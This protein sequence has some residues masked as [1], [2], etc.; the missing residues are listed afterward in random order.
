MRKFICLKGVPLSIYISYTHKM[1]IMPFLLSN[2]LHKDVVIYEIYPKLCKLKSPLLNTHLQK[3]ILCDVSM[4]NEIEDIYIN[5][6]VDVHE[7]YYRDWMETDLLWILNT[8]FPFYSDRCKRQSIRQSDPMHH[9]NRYLWFLM[10]NEQKELMYNQANVS[11]D[12][13]EIMS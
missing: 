6:S 13:F 3:S 1:E 9:N 2:V 5:L 10:T 11:K 12:W 4:F 8:D 7:D